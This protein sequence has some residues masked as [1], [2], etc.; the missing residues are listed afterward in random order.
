[1]LRMKER[2]KKKENMKETKTLYQPE[3]GGWPLVPDHVDGGNSGTP[4]AGGQLSGSWK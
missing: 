2:K 4:P 1:M 3:G